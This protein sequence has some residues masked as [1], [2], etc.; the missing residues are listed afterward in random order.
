[1]PVKRTFAEHMAPA[2]E[3]IDTVANAGTMIPIRVDGTLLGRM[4]REQAEQKKLDARRRRMKAMTN[5]PAVQAI[6]KVV[7]PLMTPF[8]PLLAKASRSRTRAS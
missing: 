2:F 3:A 1:M 8:A 6:R 4:D 5:S 7:R